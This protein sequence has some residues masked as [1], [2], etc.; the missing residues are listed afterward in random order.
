MAKRISDWGLGIR[1]VW[2]WCEAAARCSCDR[3]EPLPFAQIADAANPKSLIPNPDP[4]HFTS[5]SEIAPGGSGSA[6]GSTDPFT[7]GRSWNMK[8]HFQR[9]DGFEACSQ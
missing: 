4:C 3:F 5:R 2:H 8:S 1:G 7:G 9:S 6:D